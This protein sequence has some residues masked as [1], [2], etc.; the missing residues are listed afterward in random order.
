MNTPG[1]PSG[2]WGWRFTWEALPYWLA[3]QLREMAELYGRLPSEGAVDTPY[4]Q[5]TTGGEAEG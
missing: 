4:R 5:S 3:P 2:N 1:A